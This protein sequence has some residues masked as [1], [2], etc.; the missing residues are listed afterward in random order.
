M[1]SKIIIFLDKNIK[2]ILVSLFLVICVGIYIQFDNQK[3]ILKNLEVTT[4][5]VTDVRYISRGAY[6]LHY[7]YVV[8]NNTYKN[9]I[10]IEKFIGNNKK[11]G[12]LGC[13]FKVYYSSENPEKSRIFLAEFEKY[14]TTVEFVNFPDQ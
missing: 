4:G 9:N 1:A 14:K 10:G 7:K 6:A 13:S 2:I 3:E 12:C 5:T 11:L 8:N